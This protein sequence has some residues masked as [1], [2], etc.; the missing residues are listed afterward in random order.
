LDRIYFAV[1]GSGL[2]HVTR[3]LEISRRVKQDEDFI[4]RFSCS[5][6]ALEYLRSHGEG[7]DNIVESPALDVE[8]TTDGS[9]SSSQFIPRFP[10]MLNTFWKQIQFEAEN[11]SKFN[12]KLMVSDSKLSPVLAVQ[13][14]RKKPSI[15]TML[16]Q[17]KVSL[18]PRFKAGKPISTI[19]ERTGGNVLGLLWSFSDEVLM[20]DLPPPYTIAE[21]NVSRTDVSNIVKYVGFI[22]PSLKFSEGSLSRARQALDLDGGKP[23]AFFQISGPEVTKKKFAD[24]VLQSCW[25]LCKRYNVVIS[26]GYSSGSGEPKKLTS[27]AWLYE[28]CPIKDEL[29]VLSDM[30]VARSG[31]RTIG[32]CIDSGK[33]AVLVPIHNHSEQL[34]NAEKFSK[35]GLGI[36]IKSE[37]LR[38]NVLEESVDACVN[39]PGYK[40][41]AER[42]MTISRKHNGMDKVAEIIKSYR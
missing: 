20:T 32:E 33:P 34:G 41:N 37:N 39:N 24:I 25:N 12:P 11:I 40:K 2:G 7:S 23:L 26:M 35:L 36:E 5:D 22:S 29:F 16:N 28:W 3:V 38:S 30:I 9:F 19:Y 13:R 15:I 21:A 1:Y 4:S 18:P 8:W 17:F 6:Q 31:H 14:I 27:G 10:F 42:V